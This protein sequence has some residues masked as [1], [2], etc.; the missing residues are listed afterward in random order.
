[1]ATLPLKSKSWFILIGLT[2]GLLKLL[3]HTT[4]PAGAALERT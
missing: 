3:Y 4:Y 1:M 2:P